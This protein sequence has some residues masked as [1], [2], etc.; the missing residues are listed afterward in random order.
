MNRIRRFWGG[1]SRDKLNQPKYRK[2]RN[3][4]V[5][6]RKWCENCLLHGRTSVG[7]QLDHIIP[8]SKRPDLKYDERNVQ[9]LCFDC[10]YAKT[11]AENEPRSLAA[12]ALHSIDEEGNLVRV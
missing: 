5:A 7:T 6:E 1:D 2:W 4:I 3:R 11:K 9:L 8:R 12:T 10:H